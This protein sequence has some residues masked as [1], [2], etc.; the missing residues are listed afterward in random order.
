MDIV[1]GN[2]ETFKRQMQSLGLSYDWSRE[3]ATTDPAY[4]RWTQWLFIQ[5]FKMGLLYKK[6]TPINWCPSCKTGLSEE[7]VLANGTHER[8]GNAITKKDL[9]QW[10][11]R[12]TSYADRLLKDL[13]GLDWPEGI[14]TMQRNWIGK[15]EGVNINHKVDGME[16]ELKTFSAYP[17]W[18]FADT[19]IVMAPEHPLV[20]KLTKGTPY[21]KEVIL[22][23][24]EHK[25]HTKEELTKGLLEKKGI[26]TGKYAQDPF[27]PGRKMPIWLANFALMDFG[28][29]II[30]CSAH[31]VRDY[32]FAQKYNIELAEVVERIN[33]NVPINAHDNTGFEKFGPIHR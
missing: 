30:R 24:N 27:N 5:F 15:K 6:N 12:I 33:K 16:I 2:I 19:F 3:F 14:L 28:T 31:D 18:L 20:S 22:F 9:P 7:E 11:F 25:G 32:E 23:I 8:C 17:A 21:E 1:P 10:I 26:F 29:G 13:D 4:Y